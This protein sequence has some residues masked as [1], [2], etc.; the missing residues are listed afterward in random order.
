MSH[1]TTTNQPPF[2]DSADAYESK[3]TEFLSIRD[4][5]SIGASVVN[6]WG[7]HLQRGARV[8]ELGCG[9]GYP[10]THVL[11]SLGLNVHAIE[12]SPTLASEFRTRFPDVAIQCCKV[13]ES[14]FFDQAY[15]G[16]VAIGLIFLLSERE[17]IELINNVGKILRIN[18]RFLFTAPKEKGKWLDMNTNTACKSLGQTVY[19]DLFTTA[20]FRLFNTYSD[21]GENNYYDIERIA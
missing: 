7:Q 3:A 18:S 1:E 12:S 9:G 14:T 20:G 2:M 4:H 16:A 21:E 8:L 15:D 19:E 11:H 10:I 17:Q 13:Q 5:S 6:E